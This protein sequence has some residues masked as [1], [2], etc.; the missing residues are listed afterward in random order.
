M[1]NKMKWKDTIVPAPFGETKSFKVSST[2]IS[3]ER[4]KEKNHAVHYSVGAILILYE[5]I[6]IPY[7][8]VKK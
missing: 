2:L 8:I 1:L 4:E 6:H 7:E 5:I 3:L